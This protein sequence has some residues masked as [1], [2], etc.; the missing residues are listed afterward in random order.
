MLE[1]RVRRSESSIGVLE[2]GAR[3]ADRPPPGGLGYSNYEWN[4]HMRLPY[5]RQARVAGTYV[6]SDACGSNAAATSVYRSRLAMQL[7]GARARYETRYANA[8]FVL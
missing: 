2:L 3:V 7:A 4:I 8:G 5:A 1:L 6:Q